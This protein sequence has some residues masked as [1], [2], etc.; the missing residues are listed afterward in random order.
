VIVSTERAS[1]HSSLRDEQARQTRLRI[2]QAAREL[3]ASRGFT[4]TTVVEIARLAGVSPAT[5]YAAFESKAG[6]VVAMLEEME[7]SAG[8]GRKL[9]DLFETADP[10][11]LLRDYVSIHC[12]LFE[13][14]A[15]I[16][17]AAMRAIEDPEVAALAEEGDRHRR[18]VID[19]IT[20]RWKEAGI[21]KAGLDEK[22]AADRL[23]L[24]TTVEGYLN[25]VDRLGWESDEYQTWLTQIAT[26]ELFGVER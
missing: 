14:N 17:R 15:D 13:G 3:F 1:Y 12:E 10:L 6:V 11:E 24:L 5:V 7:E 21:L 19:F 22:G 18:E 8:I 20:A 25:A 23:W 9:R 2:R 4:A 26:T 16:L